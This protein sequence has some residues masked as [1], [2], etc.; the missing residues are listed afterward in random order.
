ML[1]IVSIVATMMPGTAQAQGPTIDVWYGLNQSFGHL[2]TSQ[3]WANILGNVSDPDG[4]ASLVYTLNGGSQVSLTIGPDGRRLQSSGDFNVDLAT[5]DLLEGNNSV[6]ITATDNLSNQTVTTVTVN[7]TSAVTATLP[8]TVTWSDATNIEDEAQLV[9]GLWALE[10][11]SQVRTSIIGYDRLISIGETSWTDYD[12]KV[13]ITIHGTSGSFGCGILLRWNGHTDNPIAGTQPKSGYLPLGA[14]CWY[15]SGRIEIYGNNGDI[16]GTDSRTLTLGTEYWFQAR[17]ETI[18]GVGGKYSFKVWEVGQP[19]PPT[20]DIVGQEALSDPQNGSMMLISHYADA[21]YGDVEVTEVPISISDIEVTMSAG[22]T[23]ATVTWTTNVDSDGYV[24]YGP[25]AAYENGTVT[26]PATGTSHSVVLTGLTPDN[27][28]H[29]QITATDLSANSTSSGDLTFVAATSSIVS[30]DF[31]A[32]T[33][34]TGL[35]TFEDPLSDGGAYTL[36]GTNTSDAWLNI[37]VPSGTA[38][39]VWDNGIEVPHIWQAANDV[40]FEVEVKFESSV[41][42]QYQEQGI[43][44]KQDSG[45]YM[46][47]EFYSSSTETR[48]IAASFESMTPQI[49]VNTQITTTGVAPLYMRV[50]RQGNQWTQTYSYDGSTWLN[51]AIFT[52]PINVTAIGIYGGNAGGN[53]AH[54]ASFD[55]FFNTDSPIVPED[56]TLPWGI[57]DVQAIATETEAIITWTTNEFTNSSVAYGPTT[58]YEDGSVSDAAYVTDHSITLTGL[59]PS[60]TY[61]YQV[62]SEDMSANSV[63]SGDYVFAT[64][65][66]DPSG[67][68]SD[69]FNSPTLDT[70]LWEWV[71]PLFDATLTMTG[72][73][74]PDAWVNMSV[75]AGVEHQVYTGGIEAAHILQTANNTDFEVEAKFESPVTLQYQEQGIVVKQDADNFLRLEFFS[76]TTATVLYARGFTT[77]TSPTYINTT[78]GSSGVMPLYMRVKRE[79]DL[80]TLSTSFDGLDWTAQ[81]PFTHT[82]VVTKI[83][84]YSG[85]GLGGT[86]PAHTASVDYFFNTASPIDPEDGPGGPLTPEI[87]VIPAVDTTNCSG[88]PTFQFYIDYGGT[89]EIRGFDVTFTVDPAVVTVNNLIADFVEGTYLSSHGSTTFF[90]LDL[91]SGTYVASG[92]ILGGT[93]G[94]VGPGDLFDV[95]F[96]PVAGGTS[97]I[98]VTNVELRDPD[99]IPIAAVWTGGSVLV[100]CTPPTMEPIAEAEGQYFNTAPSFANFGFDDDVALDTGEYQIDSGGWVAIF[101]THNLPEYNDD[102]WTLPGF[103]GLPDGT[104]TVYFRV[105]DMAGNQNGEG[106]P[107]TYTW[108]FYKDTTA[109]DPPTNFVANPGNTRT[110]LTWTN[111]TGD[112][113]WAGVEIRRVGWRDYPQYTGTGPDYPANETEGAFV[114]QTVAN[115]YDDEPLLPPVTPRDIYYYS[116]FSYDLAG[117]YSVYN[118]GASD[119]TTNYWLG[120]IDST[121]TVDSG[122]LIVF[123]GAYASTEG[124]PG[125]VAEVD[126]GPSDD[127]SRFGIPLPDD[128]VQFEDL[129]IFAMNYGNVTSGG[130]SGQLL[131][132]KQVP[133]A[134]RVAFR[135]ETAQTRSPDGT[136]QI[137]VVLDNSAIDLKGIRLTVDYGVG[138]QLVRVEQGALLR[139]GG[140]KF[141][142]TL[143]AEPGRVHVD[144]A[145]LGIGTAFEGSGELVRLVI[146]PGDAEVVSVR[147]DGADLRDVNNKR[148]VSETTGGSD[149]LVPTVSSLHQNRPNPF[150]PVTTVSYDVATPG[151]VSI[152]IYNVSGQLVRTILDEF[153]G[154]GRHE[155]V[156]DGRNDHGATVTSGVYFY[157]MTAP[158]FATQTRKMLLLK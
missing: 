85:N 112:A 14:I 11:P 142:G 27:T 151:M 30:D 137:S 92:A 56:P 25:T 87:S 43:L 33:L 144:I 130:V 26:D 23:E 28:Y 46:R 127:N 90:A 75:P 152:R 37:S 145:A 107:D 5:A 59:T 128:A 10:A 72:A 54:T 109:P 4:V 121:G 133:L 32:P 48:I 98:T 89:T 83:G 154:V 105:S 50:K 131:A 156:W 103:A 68:V 149:A 24:D 61:H 16:L 114:V 40:D 9:D 3:P 157:R 21:S 86:S 115:A 22:N 76:T 99:N 147:F 155:A 8:T 119:R 45:D 12:V 18:A 138:N 97:A 63:S 141:V 15:R 78:I 67:I 140:S 100:D 135:F 136:V 93:A 42:L 116:A 60:A 69:D 6:V 153:K 47:F 44:V 58:A 125:W 111:P 53:P 134:E 34:N 77:T 96:T 57:T 113:T 94:A 120:D 88:S 20:W 124:G 74:T 62:T 132:E 31:S 49:R 84:P 1:V 17:V 146:R 102:G 39:E 126:F 64:T 13:P 139:G 80:W 150:N 66:A 36:T 51:G 82:M 95:V 7:Y 35:W 79:G 122:D 129:M 71:D 143:P 65:G 41:N 108:Q 123:S 91:G 19:E 101:T 110:H 55:Y 106:T 73:G 117:N 118:A 70:A 158:G 81:T 148:E 38:H 104:H 29:Y 2:G 52:H